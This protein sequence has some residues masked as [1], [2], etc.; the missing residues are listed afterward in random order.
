MGNK[1]MPN[2]LTRT[3][4]HLPTATP[5]PTPNPHPLST[6]TQQ[7]IYRP[8]VSTESIMVG[9]QYC[10]PPHAHAHDHMSH[11]KSRS[12]HTG[13]MRSQIILILTLTLQQSLYWCQIR[14][15]HCNKRNWKSTTGDLDP[16]KTTTY[17]L[18]MGIPDNQKRP[19]DH[20][21]LCLQHM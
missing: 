9:N 8:N 13:L 7:W 10:G 14:Y 2:A 1:L 11:F 15:L 17:Q 21:T 18:V 20:C 12:C 19:L 5:T 6:T 4:A 3:R 16:V